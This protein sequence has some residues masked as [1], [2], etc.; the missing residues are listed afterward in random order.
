MQKANF[1]KFSRVTFTPNPPFQ[2]GL[3]ELAPTLS[4]AFGCARGASIPLLCKDPDH[5]APLKLWCPIASPHEQ[6]ACKMRCHLILSPSLCKTLPLKPL[7][8]P[9][10]LVFMLG[11]GY[12]GGSPTAVQSWQT[13]PLWEPSP[14]HPILVYARGFAVFCVYV[15]I[16]CFSVNCVIYVCLQ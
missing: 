11:R 10:W 5:R 16:L 2:E 12:R 7:H 9:M 13:C 1:Q 4:T 3:H 8:L 15:C 14:S 6:I